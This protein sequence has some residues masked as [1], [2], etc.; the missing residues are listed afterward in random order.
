MTLQERKKRI[1]ARGEHS[2]HC[3]VITGNAAVSKEGD[4]V[5]VDAKDNS[6][7]IKHILESEWLKGSEV[8]TKEHHDIRLEKGKYE[9]VQQQEFDPFERIIRDVID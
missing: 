2:N 8:W 6:V 9:F 1:I 4:L 3:H 5:I 7:V